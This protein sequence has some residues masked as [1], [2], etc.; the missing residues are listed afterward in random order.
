MS[1]EYVD[2]GRIFEATWLT[3]LESSTIGGK[4]VCSNIGVSFHGVHD[5]SRSV[6]IKKT[7]GYSI[8][9]SILNYYFRYYLIFSIL[10]ISLP[11]IYQR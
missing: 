3:D 10:L 8:W 11:Y 7:L 5:S 2:D 4:N 9:I 1:I 6:K